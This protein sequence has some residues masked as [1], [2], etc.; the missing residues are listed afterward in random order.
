MYDDMKP[1][2]SKGAHFLIDLYGCDPYQ[3]NSLT[4]WKKT[5]AE[6]AQAASMENLHTHFHQFQPQGI[7][8]F[9]LLSTSH[10]SIHSWPEYSYV[11][12]D[13]FS[14]AEDALTTKAVDHLLKSVFHSRKKVQK[15]MRGYTVMEYLESPIFAT[16]RVKRIGIVKELA[17]MTSAFQS[18]VVA[19]LKKFGRSL[20]IDGLI[21]TSEYDHELYDK[22]MLS[23]LKKT[24][25]QILI[26]GGG[27]GYIAE[28]A[29]KMYPNLKITIVDLDV[30]VVDVVKKY[31]NQKVFSHPNV[32]LVIGNAL[33]YLKAHNKQ[34]P[35]DGIVLDLTD[36]PI[37]TK[38]ARKKLEAFY[39][40]I[41]ILAK[42]VLKPSGW[43]SA[44]SGASKVTGK[45][46]DS[47]KLIGSKMKSI[48]HNAQRR[49]VLIPSFG[50]KNS[51]MYAKNVLAT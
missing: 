38:G 47:A 39:T 28:K 16:G 6:A 5:L 12:C 33:Q 4:F 32:K 19:E 31:L 8:G 11:A 10:I 29:L 48:F 25:Q 49:D 22:T 41:F 2:K 20:V 50:E 9:L 42:D 21:Q 7:T 44:Q 36:S 46:V 17:A 51:F 1:Q 13:I 27:D 15:I 45:H 37:G 26:L 3:L 34:D 18:I 35:V 23:S 43:I 30:S 14:C 24:D 40:E